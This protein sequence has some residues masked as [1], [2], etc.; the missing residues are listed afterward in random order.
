MLA[1]ARPLCTPHGRWQLC[2]CAC[3][4]AAS[5]R[6][7]AL[8][9]AV[10]QAASR[11]PL[12][13]STCL[14]EISRPPFFCFVQDEKDLPPKMESQKFQTL[15]CQNPPPPGRKTQWRAAEQE[16]K[17]KLKNEHNNCAAAIL[18]WRPPRCSAMLNVSSTN[19]CKF[20]STILQ[21]KS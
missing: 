12:E 17:S 4:P 15:D 6:P 11:V 8:S 21:G 5:A 13:R 16:L 20:F 9:R 14:S 19:R 1:Q 3:S 10:P 7:C 2:L 18:V